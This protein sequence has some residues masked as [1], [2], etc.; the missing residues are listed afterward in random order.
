MKYTYLVYNPSKEYQWSLHKADCT[1]IKQELK[2]IRTDSGFPA[3]MG[4]TFEATNLNEALDYIIDDDI[5]EMGYNHNAVRVAPCCKE[6]TRAIKAQN[7]KGGLSK[8]MTTM[9]VAKEL[10]VELQSVYRFID[11][12]SLKA[13]K[14]G[15]A[16][17]A[18]YRIKR[19]DL[20]EFLYERRRGN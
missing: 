17:R 1:D 5:K 7:N 11:N 9:E 16:P 4:E 8:L 2:G 12:G 18:H 6:G 20:A 13:I 15:D 10:S 19:K 14:L 3:Q